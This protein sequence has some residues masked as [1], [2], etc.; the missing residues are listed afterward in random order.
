MAT[1]NLGKYMANGH[2]DMARSGQI[3]AIPDSSAIH[4]SRFSSGSRVHAK[5]GTNDDS[6]YFG[7]IEYIINGVRVH[8]EDDN[9]FTDYTIT[10][11]NAAVKNKYFWLVN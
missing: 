10:R 6:F 7:C 8:W 3:K 11:F 5:Y 2:T 1:R 9:S 4:D